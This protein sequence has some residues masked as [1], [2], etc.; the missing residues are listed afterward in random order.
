MCV[1]FA[2]TRTKHDDAA[3]KMSV[4]MDLSEGEDEQEE[5]SCHSFLKL[6]GAKILRRSDCR[7]MSR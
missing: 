6:R 4:N 1:C 5:E 2:F 7:L 3:I